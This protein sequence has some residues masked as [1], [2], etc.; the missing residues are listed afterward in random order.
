MRR[1]VPSVK[2]SLQRLIQLADEDRMLATDL[3]ELFTDAFYLGVSDGLRGGDITSNTA[4]PFSMAAQ[5]ERYHERQRAQS[6]REERAAQD[7]PV[8][9]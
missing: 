3:W 8:N 7:R 1:N 5:M 4:N 9:V 2:P 6:G